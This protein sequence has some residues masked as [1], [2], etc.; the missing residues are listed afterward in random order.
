MRSAAAASSACVALVVVT[1]LITAAPRLAA[2]DVAWNEAIRRCWNDASANSS[3]GCYYTEGKLR[4]TKSGKQC[5]EQAVKA[6]RQHDQEGALRWILACQCG[7]GDAKVKQ[8]LR[9]HDDE[10]VQLVVDAYGLF[11]Q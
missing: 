6:A 3:F 7:V 2:Q 4:G 10:A 5:L 11:V 1:V 9:D 8:S